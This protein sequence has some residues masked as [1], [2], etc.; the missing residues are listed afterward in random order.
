MAKTIPSTVV[1][2]VLDNFRPGQDVLLAEWETLAEHLHYEY[3][4]N[5]TR[6]PG[7]MFDQP[8]TTT[9]TSY[10]TTNSNATLA[11]YD[12]NDW[13]GFWVFRRIIDNGAGT[14]I[15]QL[16]FDSYARNLDVRCSCVRFD[17]EDGHSGS[18]TSSFVLV[19]NHTPDTD[20]N[21]QVDTFSFT[22]AQ[23]SRGGSTANGLA[24]FACYVEAKV[25]TSGTGYLFGFSVRE[26]SI[27]SA[28]QLPES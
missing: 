9:S 22:E 24:F 26:T 21:W 15:Y 25:P 14:K 18:S 1:L 23:A 17:T 2:P 10:T 16:Q 19:N 6:M 12:L 20:T 27:S 5:G 7:M 3:A 11:N 28:T 13:Q 8:W 4:R